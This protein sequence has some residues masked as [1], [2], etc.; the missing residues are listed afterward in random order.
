MINASELFPNKEMAC[1]DNS[2]LRET[3][4]KMKVMGEEEKDDNVL[5]VTIELSSYGRACH[6]NN[7]R[8]RWSVAG[9]ICTPATLHSGDD[10]VLTEIT[11]Q[12]T[13]N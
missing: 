5:R 1:F 10:V 6:S 7:V 9:L 13:H 8:E 11:R 12:K 3:N 2:E 4:K